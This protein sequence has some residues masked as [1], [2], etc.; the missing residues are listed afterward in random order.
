MPHVR[1]GLT[2]H[3]VVQTASTL[4]VAEVLLGSFFRED[5]VHSAAQHLLNAEDVKLR[6]PETLLLYVGNQV[7][8]LQ[9][10][11]CTEVQ[12]CLMEPSENRGNFM[13]L[14]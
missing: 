3:D 12:L 7:K 1:Q 10:L 11:A 8:P 13:L 5:G 2:R 14:C 9:H 6:A 4:S